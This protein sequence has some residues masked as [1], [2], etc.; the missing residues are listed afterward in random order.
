[1][2]LSP[3]DPAHLIPTLGLLYGTP[4]GAMNELVASL[5]CAWTVRDTAGKVVGALGSRSATPAGTELVGGAL[6]GEH[7]AEVARLLLRAALDHAPVYAYAEAERLPAE[8]LSAAGFR[9]VSAYLRLSGL[10]PD[11]RPVV[12]EGFRIVPLSEVTSLADRWA[13]QESY[14]DQLGHT[15]TSEKAIMPNAGGSLDALGRLAYDPDGRPA[16][17]C[18]ATLDGEQASLGTPGV[19]TDLRGSGLRRA[20]LLSVC[21]A[22]RA[23]GATRLSLEAWGDAPRDTDADLALG[24]SLDERTPI[25]LSSGKP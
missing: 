25:Y 8:A 3:A 11:E 2:H 16:G 17:V 14:A 20:L 12:P 7:Q 15:P 6:P 22:V 5:T 23:A 4:P 19:R 10:V 13:A 9:E 21:Q 18:R 24:L 1:M